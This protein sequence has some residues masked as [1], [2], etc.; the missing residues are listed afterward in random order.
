MIIPLERLLYSAAAGTKTGAFL[1]SFDEYGLALGFK[2]LP[3]PPRRL[4]GCDDYDGC[5]ACENVMYDEWPYL[6]SFYLL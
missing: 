1:R 6:E 3:A 4:D 5:D 2:L